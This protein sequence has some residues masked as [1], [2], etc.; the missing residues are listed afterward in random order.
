MGYLS[1]DTDVM[2]IMLFALHALDYRAR[3]SY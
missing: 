2:T 1:V 3:V